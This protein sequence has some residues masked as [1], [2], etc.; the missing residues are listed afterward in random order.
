MKDTGIG[1]PEEDLEKIFQPFHLVDISKSVLSQ[2]KIERTGL[3]LAITN[4]YV[5]MHKGK[6]WAENRVDEGTIIHV[7]LPKGT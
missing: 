7:V 1:I 5:K 6:I 4:E 3:G 2:I